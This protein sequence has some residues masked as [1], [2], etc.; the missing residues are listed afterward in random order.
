VSRVSNSHEKAVSPLV[1]QS[2]TMRP[3]PEVESAYVVQHIDVTEEVNRRLRES[4]LRRLMETPS[5]SQKRK[6]DNF[7]DTKEEGGT[8]PEEDQRNPS[9]AGD[10][11]R[12]PTKRLRF[13]GSFEQ[14]TGK[15]KGD[16]Q[17]QGEERGRFEDRTN[18]KR[19]R[20]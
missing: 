16:H 6:F 19:R 3:K 14:T 1:D 20:M 17:T 8:G 12:T 5:T 13:S 18:V 7:E 2:P 11:E 15:R 4:R 10:T 9:S